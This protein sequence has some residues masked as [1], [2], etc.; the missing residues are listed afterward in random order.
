VGL[1]NLPA[2]L[3][4]QCCRQSLLTIPAARKVKKMEVVDIQQLE[5]LKFLA[6]K[7]V[8]RAVFIK[9]YFVHK[10]HVLHVYPSHIY[11][12]DNC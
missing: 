12:C 7:V 8:L 9:K 10:V 1:L 5:V 3:E 6:S 2:M 4:D 11:I